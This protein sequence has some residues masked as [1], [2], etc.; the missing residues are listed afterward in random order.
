MKNSIIL[1]FRISSAVMLLACNNTTTHT[2]N[3]NDSL[4]KD[5]VQVAGKDHTAHPS[6]SGAG[7]S[8]SV[9]DTAGRLFLNRAASA[10]M[11]AVALGELSAKNGSSASVKRFGEMMVKDQADA[12]SHLKTVADQLRV[13]LPD[14]MLT[15]HAHYRMELDKKKGAAFDKAYMKITVE[16]HKADMEEFEKAAKTNNSLIRNFALQTLPVL[17][18]QLDS[19]SAI[20]KKKF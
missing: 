15:Q 13:A 16:N 10:G 8:T 3:T 19:A 2:V 20:L 4:T 18:K 6:D 7:V 1:F 14:S 11:L 9:V 17:Q 12:G 5:S